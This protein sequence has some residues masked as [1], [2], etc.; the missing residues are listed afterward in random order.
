VRWFVERY[1]NADDLEPDPEPMRRG[2]VAHEALEI[3]LRGLREDTGSARI[4]PERLPEVRGRLEGV[5]AEVAA[6]ASISPSPER[7][8]VAARRLQ[9]DLERYLETA[10]REGGDY[11]PVHFE[12]GFGFEDE[13]DSLPALELGDL[14]LRGRIDRID[15]D[16]SGRRAVVVDYKASKKT[17]GEKWAEDRDFQAALYLRAAQELL[18]L[19]PAGAFYQPLSGPDL[20]P[21]GLIAEDADP[22]FAAVGKDRRAPEEMAAMVDTVLE[23]AHVAAGEARA[24]R[25]EP[26]PD[27][28]TGA[29]RCAYP[30][31]CRCDA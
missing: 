28:C 21:R 27:T 8:R 20:R 23:L 26:R 7:R 15:V 14:R 31:L 19:E 24:G 17:P 29:K 2:A 13:P 6:R 30:G 25:L 18:G 3:T 11:E 22:G 12:A 4:T 16:P 10:A 5:L 9:A 1:L